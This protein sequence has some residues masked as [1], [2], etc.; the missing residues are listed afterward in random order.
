MREAVLQNIDSS[1]KTPQTHNYQEQ[2]FLQ[3]IDKLVTKFYK[4][5]LKLSTCLLIYQYPIPFNYQVALYGVP[6]VC[7][8]P[9]CGIKSVQPGKILFQQ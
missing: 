7:H 8:S 6:S 9:Q 2:T 4:N 1:H 5:K 3:N